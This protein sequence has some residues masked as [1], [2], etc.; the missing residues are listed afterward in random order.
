MNA[1]SNKNRLLV[2]EEHVEAVEEVGAVAAA[3]VPDVSPWV[4]TAHAQD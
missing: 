1:L 3:A 2:A 4:A